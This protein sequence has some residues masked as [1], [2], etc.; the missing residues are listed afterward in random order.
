M[1]ETLEAEWDRRA[2][3]LSTNPQLGLSPDDL[4]AVHAVVEPVLTA[5]S[6]AVDAAGGVLGG[7]G[8]DD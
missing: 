8:T 3:F 6:A 5:P 4:L 7:T 2:A 1:R